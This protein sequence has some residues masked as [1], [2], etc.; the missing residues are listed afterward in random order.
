MSLVEEHRVPC[1]EIF[2]RSSVCNVS[3]SKSDDLTTTVEIW[4]RDSFPECV[5][6]FPLFIAGLPHNI[7]KLHVFQLVALLFQSVPQ[8]AL[9]VTVADGKG[10]HGLSIDFPLLKKFQ[11]R[12]GG[13]QIL[14]IQFVCDRCHDTGRFPVVILLPFLWCQFLFRNLNV[15]PFAKPSASFLK[16]P[17]V[18]LLKIPDNIAT[19]STSKALAD[20]FRWR[21][22]KRRRLVVMEWTQS[23]IVHTCLA[24][25]NVLTN[26]INDIGRV[27]Q[28]L[29]HVLRNS[30]HTIP[31]IFFAAIYISK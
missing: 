13:R 23:L 21:H 17:P 5:V 22:Y 16:S 3:A 10:L 27:Q 11:C 15:K 4:Q 9:L 25:R 26:D 18:L 31:S 14:L 29:H 30:T 2:S 24:K 12:H 6:V 1:V 20:T 19:L 7:A 8:L 28:R